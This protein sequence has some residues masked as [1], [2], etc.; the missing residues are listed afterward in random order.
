MRNLHAEYDN[1]VK[2]APW[3]L[4]KQIPFTVRNIHEEH[5]KKRLVDPY[6]WIQFMDEE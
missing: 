3:P 2:M 5:D 4:H 6:H 1:L